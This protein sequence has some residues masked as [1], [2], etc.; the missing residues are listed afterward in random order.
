MIELLILFFTSKCE[1]T[2]YGIQKIISDYYDVYT[3]PSFGTISPALKKLE[4]LKLISSRKTI[5]DGGRR[6]FY[7]SIT[8]DGMKELKQ[9]LLNDLSDNPVQ[10]F[11]NAR[12]KLSCAGVLSNEE[13]SELY[14]KIK[15]HAYLY[16]FNAENTLNN[17]YINLDFHQKIVLDNELCELNNL[18]S[19]IEELEKQNAGDSK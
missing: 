18:I 6:C 8:N 7:Y 11:S 1:L 15:T 16:K 10:F 13:L 2:M 19:L 4:S 5:S 9:I 14:S 3:K 17:E 12:I